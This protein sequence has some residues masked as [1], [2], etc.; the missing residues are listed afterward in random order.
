MVAVRDDIQVAN[1]TVRRL[2]DINLGRTK[3]M[4]Y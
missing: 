1:H 4:F 3:V 2:V